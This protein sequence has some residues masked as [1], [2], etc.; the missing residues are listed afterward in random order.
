MTAAAARTLTPVP[1]A[2]P[3]PAEAPATARWEILDSKVAIASGVVAVLGG[4]VSV[5]WV[6]ATIAADVADI[7]EEVP[8]GSYV[9]L[10]AT[11]KGL[12]TRLQLL[13]RPEP[14]RK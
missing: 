6:M 9:R 11:L 13:E 3:A 4:L 2:P 12:D 5:V 7:K 10:E 1:T 14:P 8:A